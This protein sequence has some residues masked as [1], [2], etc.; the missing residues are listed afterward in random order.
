MKIDDYRGVGCEHEALAAEA[1]LD[2][3]GGHAH[4]LGCGHPGL[5]CVGVYDGGHKR[6]PEESVN[7]RFIYFIRKGEADHARS[8]GLRDRGWAVELNGQI[9]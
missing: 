3:L 6:L 1:I 9:K 2:G 8:V 4:G 7:V 5:R